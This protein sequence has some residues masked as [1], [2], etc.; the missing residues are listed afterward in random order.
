MYLSY[1][2]YMEVRGQPERLI[3]TFHPFGDSVSCHW[4]PVSIWALL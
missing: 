3:L 4:G 1:G 2:L